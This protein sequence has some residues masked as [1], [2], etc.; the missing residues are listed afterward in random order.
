MRETGGYGWMLARRGIRVAGSDAFHIK[1]HLPF[2]YHSGLSGW[3]YPLA[4][5][6]NI[7]V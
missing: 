2:V 5:L 1:P 7:Y 4:L 6:E 3:P